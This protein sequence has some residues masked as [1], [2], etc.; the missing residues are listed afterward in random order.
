MNIQPFRMDHL[1]GLDFGEPERAEMAILGSGVVKQL[2]DADGPAWTL[3]NDSGEVVGCFGMQ[4]VGAD[5]VIWVLLSDEAREN[6]FGLHRAAA[7]CLDMIEAG[8]GVTRILGLINDDYAPAR[9]WIE[10]FGFEPDAK[11]EISGISYTRYVK[12]PRAQ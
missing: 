3:T 12:W 11:V 5:G 10:N 8:T 2:R 6:P 7:H 4:V 1:G 9:R